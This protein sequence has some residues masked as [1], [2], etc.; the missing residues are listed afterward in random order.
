M[1]RQRTRSGASG[2]LDARGEPRFRAG[3]VHREA[4]MVPFTAKRNRKISARNEAK[5]IDQKSRWAFPLS[6]LFFNLSYWTYY[7]YLA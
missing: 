7:L 2:E 6:F 1:E 5:R 4:Q 3:G